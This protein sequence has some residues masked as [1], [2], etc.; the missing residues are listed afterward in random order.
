MLSKARLAIVVGCLLVAAFYGRN[1]SAGQL[2]CEAATLA[3]AKAL[4]IQAAEILI[5]KGPE[6]AFQRFSDPEDSFID[7]D[8]YVFVL[9]TA[10]RIWFNAAFPTPPGRNIL[11]SRDPNGRYFVQDMIK[12][13]NT[14]GEG[15]AEY[16][17]LSP[18]TGEMTP[19]SAYVVKVGP[20]LVAVGAYGVLSL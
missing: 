1:A 10:G 7:R 6:I 9:D 15:W 19:K 3:E 5:N 11:G 16:E 4:S 17:W 12:V 18:C 8:L 20:L 2:G 14:V 13:A